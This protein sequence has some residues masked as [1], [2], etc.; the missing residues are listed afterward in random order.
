M[1]SI[2]FDIECGE[3][4]LNQGDNNTVVKLQKT[5]DGN[6]HKTLSDSNQRLLIKAL[7]AD[8]SIK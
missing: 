6:F 4:I 1:T 7:V 5:S 3:L 2:Y 8:M